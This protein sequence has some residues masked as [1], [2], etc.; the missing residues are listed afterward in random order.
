M[1][2]II[3]SNGVKETM[4]DEKFSKEINKIER[5]DLWIGM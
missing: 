4:S 2:Q 5:I 1:K 3:Y